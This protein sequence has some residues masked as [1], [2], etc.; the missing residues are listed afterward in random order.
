MATATTLVPGKYYE[1]KFH[2]N[3]YLVQ[4]TS[5]SNVRTNWCTNH[6][7]GVREKYVVTGGVSGAHSITE[8]TKMHYDI[9]KYVPVNNTSAKNLLEK[10]Y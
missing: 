5:R 6:R 3:T 1:V 4:A 10:E 9:G 7:S 2:D 8:I